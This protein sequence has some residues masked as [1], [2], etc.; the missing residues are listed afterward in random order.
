MFVNHLKFSGITVYLLTVFGIMNLS[1]CSNDPVII[2]PPEIVFFEPAV[3]SVGDTITLYGTDFD[4]VR[5]RVRVS[6]S[7]CEFSN[8]IASRKVIPVEIVNDE[9]KTIVPDGAFSGHL[10]IE[11]VDLINNANPFEAD[12]FEISSNALPVRINQ[13][14]GNV[15]K[16]FFSSEA[17]SFK[18]VTSEEAEQYLMI[19]F[20]SSDPEDPSDLSQYSF[21]ADSPCS[22][23]RVEDAKTEFSVTTNVSG[24]DH[25]DLTAFM[26]DGDGARRRYDFEKRRRN[27]C[28]LAI[29]SVTRSDVSPEITDFR[30]NTAT[31]APQTMTFSVYADPEGSTIDPSSFTAVTA[32]LVYEG[33]HTLVYLD[34]MTDISCITGS[35]TIALGEIFDTSIYQKNR[36]A[37][38]SE[39]DIDGNRK[40]A[41]LL[42]PVVNLLTPSGTASTEGYIAG[43]FMPGDLI[44]AYMNPACTNAMEVFYTIVPDPEGI[45]ENTYEK[46][47]ALLA[48]EGVLGHEFLHMIMFNYRVLD[49]GNGILPTYV[50]ETWVDEGLAH[51][52]EDLNCY[53]EDNVKRANRFLADPGTVSLIHGGN[54]IPERGASFLFFRY[55]GDRFGETVFKKLVQSKETGI[56]NVEKATGMKFFEI[57]SDW[58]A[59]LFLDDLEITDD[60][61][62][63]YSSLNMRV[64][65]LPLYYSFADYCSG[66]VTGEISS[67]GPEYLLFSLPPLSDYNF[68][69]EVE[70]DRSMNAVI[71]RLN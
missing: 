23:V 70:E 18:S 33:I 28:L 39:S 16:I 13:E 53:D 57:F 68:T 48:I 20:E 54:S 52:A 27:D 64:D 55:L 5:S 50:E 35:E 24:R 2:V 65:F 17:Y 21:A 8:P 31:M 71:I 19:L 45:Y 59:T 60:T 63:T 4:L 58:I 14:A 32:D 61:R 44:P 47:K 56:G 34:Q 66:P 11:F 9:I 51:I 12:I 38:G 62:F 3:A 7:P 43:F 22:N 67:M 1:G 41:I 49:Y 26:E 37:F 36:E 29:T 46:D 69:I 6:F 40:V 25:K 30:K 10:R 15:A 42:S